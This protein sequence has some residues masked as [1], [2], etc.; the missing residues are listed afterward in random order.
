MILW[1]ILLILICTLV[2]LQMAFKAFFH[3]VGSRNGYT[4]FGGHDGLAAVWKSQTHGL[5][6]ALQL[7]F[8]SKTQQ[9]L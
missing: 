9:S 7:V 2:A 4:K 8:I 3:L 5:F 1:D 6:V